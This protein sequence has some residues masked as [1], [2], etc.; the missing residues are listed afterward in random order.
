MLTT[1]DLLYEP[2][3]VGGQAAANPDDTQSMSVEKGEAWIPGRDLCPEAPHSEVCLA[4]VRVVHEHDRPVA[5]LRQPRLEVVADSLVGVKAVDV[6]EI[7]AP[8]R[9]LRQGVVERRP[10]EPGKCAEMM[11]VERGPLLEHIFAVEASLV[12][13]LPRVHGI[14]RGVEPKYLNRLRERRVA[15]AGVRPELHDRARPQR[16]DQPERERNM[17]YPAGRI[18]EPHRLREDD[19]S[20]EQF[21]GG[22]DSG[23]HVFFAGRIRRLDAGHYTEGPL[24]GPGCTHESCVVVFS[25][26]RRSS[27]CATA[28]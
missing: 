5:Q 3:H 26:T 12:I 8:V 11:I 10:Y 6:Q 15:H 24:H 22:N 20:Q 21:A 25:R 23:H 7:N 1:V 4:H 18:D 13:T 14:G 17:R 16:V 9:E 2:P 28:R 19:G 27:A